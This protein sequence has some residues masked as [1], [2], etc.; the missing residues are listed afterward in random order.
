M[1]YLSPANLLKG[2]AAFALLVLS[3]S[4]ANAQKP[5]SKDITNLFA[6][7]KEHATLADDDA[8][9]LESYTRSGISWRLQADK[10]NQIKE[11]T[12]ALLRD[13]GDM[14]QMRDEGSGWQQD[15][16]DQLQPV[17]TGIA[18]HLNA[19]IQFQR[20]NPT[21]TKMPPFIDLV[22]EN[23]EYTSKAASLIHDIVDYGAAQ[24]M[25]KSLQDRLSLAPSLETD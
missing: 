19:T 25:A 10:L 15:A 17:L 5:D 12:N 14:A 3:S 24:S 18:D 8:Q 1:K 22:R 6:E 13:Y 20:E 4:I 7:I 11:H 16:I 2:A 21:H 23:S 9:K